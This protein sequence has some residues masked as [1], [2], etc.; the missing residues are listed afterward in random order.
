MKLKKYKHGGSSKEQ[1]NSYLKGGQVKLDKNNDGEL[2]EEDF[3]L[4]RKQKTSMK[5]KK[6]SLY[7]KYGALVKAMKRY[8]NGGETDP[9]K[10][11]GTFDTVT[12]VDDKPSGK[13]GLVKTYQWKGDSLNRAIDK[14]DKIIDYNVRKGVFGSQ[15]EAD[16]FRNKVHTQL[17]R[18]NFG[19]LQK[20]M[21][22][23][24]QLFK[25]AGG[26]MGA[27]SLFNYVDLGNMNLKQGYVEVEPSMISETDEGATMEQ[28][29]P[30]QAAEVKRM[31]KETGDSERGFKG[32]AKTTLLPDGTPA[33]Q[34][35]DEMLGQFAEL[36]AQKDPNA[37][38]PKK[39]FRPT[40]EY[41]AGLKAYRA[42]LR[43]AQETIRN[44]NAD[45]RLLSP[46][47]KKGEEGQALLAEIKAIRNDKKALGRL[48][49]QLSESNGFADYEKLRGDIE[50]E[51]ASDFFN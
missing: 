19:N 9:P 18:G 45:Y 27:E 3:K 25:P 31:Q 22:G 42:D 1:S 38:K 6:K 30:E 23:R 13:E 4:L 10:K 16:E 14:V 44:L 34:F 36:G 26:P 41:N 47:K 40:P 21:D 43:A 46:R 24:T 17:A 51:Y 49:S 33:G 8:E 12:V 15:K 39:Q 20:W 50:F 35:S 29:T 48:G 7:A 5:T 32:S 37:P 28:L 2:T 11:G